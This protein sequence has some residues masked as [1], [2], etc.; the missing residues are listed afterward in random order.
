VNKSYGFALTSLL[1]L[2]A[3]AAFAN[4]ATTPA[5]NPN[6]SYRDP[7]TAIDCRRAPGRA[8]ALLRDSM[9]P[10]NRDGVPQAAP[11]AATAPHTSNVA[12]T[13]PAGVTAAPAETQ[14]AAPRTDHRS[15]CPS[16]TA[17]QPEKRPRHLLFL[18]L[19]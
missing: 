1:A 14:T 6:E 8:L 19:T 4:E 7:Q 2:G 17:S 11:R 16:Q 18:H 5:A 10:C 3:S 12:R 9:N 15:D 13:A